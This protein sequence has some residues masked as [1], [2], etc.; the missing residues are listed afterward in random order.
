MVEPKAITIEDRVTEVEKEL[1]LYKDK[2]IEQRAYI[3]RLEDA[4]SFDQHKRLRDH[5]RNKEQFKYTQVQVQ[6][7]RRDMGY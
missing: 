5:K 3:N 7:L 2:V 1:E 4:V 6:K